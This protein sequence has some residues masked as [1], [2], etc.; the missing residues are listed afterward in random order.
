MAAIADVIEGL[1][2]DWAKV[3]VNGLD[4]A[5]AYEELRCLEDHEQSII[6]SRPKK[7]AG[8]D[9]VVNYDPSQEW[10]PAELVDE[11]TPIHDAIDARRAALRAKAMDLSR[12]GIRAL[13][14]L[15]L[16]HDILHEIVDVFQHEGAIAPNRI[17][18]FHGDSPERVQSVQNLRLTCRAFYE[19]ASPLLVPIL[20]VRLDQASLDH[21]DRISRS[22]LIAAG[23]RA[24]RVALQYR[25][26]RLAENVMAFK[27]RRLD[28]L[29]TQEH[30]C[31]YYAETWMLGGY[32]YDDETVC[33]QP[34]REYKEAIDNYWIIRAAW[35]EE[36][37]AEAK[38]R[39]EA[40]Y[41]VDAENDEFGEKR[42][43]AEYLRILL[44]GHERYCQ[45]HE[46]QHRLASDGSFVNTLAAAMVRMPRASALA[47]TDVIQD[48]KEAFFD[49]PTTLLTPNTEILTRFM[50][51][52]LEWLDIERVDDEMG[53]GEFEL[54][55]AKIL[56]D[57]PIAIHKAGIRLREMQI[58]CFPL[59][60][61]Q[62]ELCPGAGGQQDAANPAWDDFRAAC[63]HLEVCNFGTGNMIQWSVRSEHLP[64]P[65]KAIVDAYLGALFSNPRVRHLD[66]TMMCYVI[67][68][69]ELGLGAAEGRYHG[70]TMLGKTNMPHLKH[71][72]VMFVTLDQQALE[73]FCASL[74]FELE[75]V[76]MFDIVL[77]GGGS[78]A[79]V[80]DLLRERVAA[81]VGARG[82]TVR[83]SFTC[84]AGGE[85]GTGRLKKN[86]RSPSESQNWSP[87]EEYSP[88]QQLPLLVQA[89]EFVLGTR[90][91]NPLRG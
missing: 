39:G 32:D 10:N 40:A 33:E 36:R 1:K 68:G 44:E 28:E 47:F 59:T 13:N 50:E 66:V 24:V 74:G 70:S 58:G 65:Q 20:E 6:S 78:W 52:P 45:K 8:E 55:A 80:L 11:Y 29:E 87:F 53:E 60:N 21:A 76:C 77:M 83:V 19:L 54:T 48:D 79:G 17:F 46:E 3:D 41:E 73:G 49:K 26:R 38:E 43:G 25:P 7:K 18:L 61:Y 9:A 62:M 27:E 56:T 22:P 16:P 72:T 85:F 88:S 84:L 14:L 67:N 4:L 86:I 71:L 51:S 31:D 90:A 69:R 2:I 23:V 82:N 34:Y 30:D 5:A 42:K 89:Q 15:D 91:D 64:A 81:A 75:Y 63:Q 35:D 37:I 12:S 57:L